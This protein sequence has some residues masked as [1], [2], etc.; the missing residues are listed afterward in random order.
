MRPLTA[1]GVVEAWGRGRNA[2]AHQR[3]I[4]LLAAA[5]PEA[6]AADLLGLSLGRRDGLL[7]ALRAMTFGD[8]LASYTHC[9][10]CDATLHFELDA[11]EIQR[12]GA[13]AAAE[14]QGALAADG[15]QVRFRAPTTGDLAA[16]ADSA[17][18]D[19]ARERLLERCVLEARRGDDAVS[20]RMLPEPL[21]AAIS[22]RIER[23]DPL[24]EVPVDLHCSI[25]GEDNRIVF[26][27][28]SFF[29]A[30]VAA[31]AERLM[32]TVYRLARSYGWSEAEIL[33]MGA[34]RRKY[35]LD[36]AAR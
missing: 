24:V 11:R 12:E 8:R 20:A 25:C 4:A 5:L 1:Q 36:L 15:F 26:D 16:A 31:A 10:Q 22:E 23:L 35:Y 2:P 19:E 30:E 28:A 27:I 18:V 14:P 3:S 9:R 17:T 33:A 32:Y 29:W 6:S 34:A 7:L 13:A 21:V